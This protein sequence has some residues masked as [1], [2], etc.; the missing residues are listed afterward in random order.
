MG[1]QDTPGVLVRGT[2]ATLLRKLRRSV[3]STENPAAMAWM[4]LSPNCVRDT[5]QM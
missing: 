4:S 2:F 5:R 1:A 3:A